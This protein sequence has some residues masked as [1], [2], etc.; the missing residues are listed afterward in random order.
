MIDRR[1]NKYIKRVNKPIMLIVISR[2]F[3]LC[4]NVI[5]LLTIAFNVYEYLLAKSID[6]NALIVSL[7]LLII[8][9]LILN[10]VIG[11][12]SD[13]TCVDVKLTLRETLYKTLTNNYAL[14]LNNEKKNG[15]LQLAVEGVNQLEQYFANYLPQFFY[16]LIAPL[17]L[18]VMYWWLNPGIGAIL[19]ISVWLIP[20]VIAL[21]Q[22]IAK[23]ILGKYWQRYIGLGLDF[24]ENLE[25]LLTLRLFNADERYQ[26]KMDDSAEGFRKATMRVLSMQLNSITIMDLVTYLGSG[27][28]IFA[29]LLNLVYGHINIF[30][31]LFTIFI[32]IE[33]FLPMRLLGSFFHVAMNGI[34]AA[35]R[36]DD[37]FMTPK[38]K[39]VQLNSINTINYENVNLAYND[40]LIINNFT[41]DFKPGLTG[42][43]GKSGSGKTT[44]YQALFNPQL[45]TQGIIKL[46][47]DIVDFNL[48]SIC[49]HIFMM[50]D[51]NFIF[52]QS[53]KDNLLMINPDL[54]TQ[55]LYD[56]LHTVGLD[57]FCNED[58]L[59]HVIGEDAT[60]LSGGQRQ[61]LVFA[62]G[63]ISNKD[64][65]IF[66]EAISSVDVSTEHLLVDLIKK[67]SQEKVV[68]LISHR[69]KNMAICDQVLFVDN[70]HVTISDYQTLVTNNPTFKSLLDTQM[71][72]ETQGG[73]V[74]A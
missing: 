26:Q 37:I 66:D 69:I 65:Y 68:I 73:N 36:L 1:M 61:R 15:I 29:S 8:S 21:T 55:A 59:N 41:Y 6:T 13:K 23:R 32:S 12:L 14:A 54:T 9:N 45:L 43:C 53:L 38:V 31:C 70:H 24:L 71:Y 19:F 35:K 18:F 57:E 44:L 49:D 74:C 58:A 27:I 20:I 7:V 34:S 48:D 3:L 17:L 56:V 67:L 47:D 11:I 4:I 5:L 50:R 63:L 64:V 52:N 25:G 42:I 62:Q 28:G 40:H 2:L 46:N 60:N 39:K 16:A 30:V 10:Y 72:F 33:F 22:T 51:T